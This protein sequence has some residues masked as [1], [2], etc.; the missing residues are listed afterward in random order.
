[1]FDGPLIVNPT[2]KQTEFAISK[3]DFSHIM[4]FD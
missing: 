1:M 2:F 3:S 4:Y